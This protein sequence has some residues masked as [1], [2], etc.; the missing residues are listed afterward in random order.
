MAQAADVENS[1]ALI[2]VSMGSLRHAWVDYLAVLAQQAMK[3]VRVPL[4]L[5]ADYDKDMDTICACI[6][7]GWASVMIDASEKSETDNVALTRE[8]IRI[9][10]AAGVAVEAQIGETWDEETGEGKIVYTSPQDAR[11]FVD[12]TGIDYLAV[13]VGNTPG[14]LA[15]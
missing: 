1:P 4:L 12:A 5:Y 7:H 10:R 14:A 8:V 2:G 6:Q 11:A 3:N 9:A 15:G 13:S